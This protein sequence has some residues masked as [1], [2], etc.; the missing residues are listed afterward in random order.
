FG[1]WVWGG[2]WLA[3]LGIKHGIGHGAVDFAGSGVVHAV[4]GVTALMGAIVLGPRIGKFGKNGEVNSLPAHDLPMAGLGCFI[5]MFGW[6]G[7]NGGSTFAAT[8][9]RF[10]IVVVNTFLA[11]MVG[12][13]AAMFMAWWGPHFKKP[14]PGMAING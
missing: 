4:G 10:T 3:T 2:G 1:N 9:T 5:L 13:L 11:G 6:F 12:S 8:E 7:F 14:D